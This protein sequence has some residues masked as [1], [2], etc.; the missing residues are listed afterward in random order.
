MAY[1]QF[2]EASGQALDKVGIRHASLV[3]NTVRQ[4]S[5][6]PVG[7][8]HS[9]RLT[10]NSNGVYTFPNTGLTLD[11]P[12]V[13]PYPNGELC[14]SRI[15]QAP[16]QVPGLNHGTGYWIVNNYGANTNFNTLDAF[17]VTNFG[18]IE[19]GASAS[20]YQL[21]KRGSF[22]D[23]NTWGTAIDAGDEVF[24]GVNGDV[25]FNLNNNINSFSQFI[26]TYAGPLP[27]EWLNFWAARSGDQEA[28]LW[29]KVNQTADVA[30]FVVESSTNGVDFKAIA[31]IPALAGAGEKTYSAIDHQP[32]DEN[33]F[34]RIRQEDT[35]GKSSYSMIRQLFFEDSDSGWLVY[36]NPITSGRM[37]I[38]AA[39]TSESYRFI[40]YDV[41]GKKIRD[42]ALTGTAQVALSQLPAGLY[43]YSIFGATK[44]IGGM[45]ELK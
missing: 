16:D 44:R 36:P 18:Y 27:V 9:A 41:A 23:V 34:Y 24:S 19:S 35:N 39:S 8:G 10:V 28:T 13:G 1:Y 26:I 11:F 15:D 7:K 33:N 4:I 37:L 42:V 6:A 20:D 3:A 29:W 5:T 43:A 40:L 12:A 31:T 2:N 30:G 38:I 14:V 45:L 32:A 25:Y 21:F 22:A 17:E